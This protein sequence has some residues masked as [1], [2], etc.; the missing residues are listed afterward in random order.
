MPFAAP[1]PIDLSIQ[2]G[3]ACALRGIFAAQN[4]ELAMST[5]RMLELAVF[6][7]GLAVTTPVLA[8]TCT[9][10]GH[11]SCTITCPAGCGA[12]YN[13]PNGPCTTFCSSAATNQGGRSRQGSSG[14]IKGATAAEI[15]RALRKK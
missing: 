5:K 12:I 3:R 10:P 7:F 1:L 6:G 13:E 11:S 15:Q 4:G 14:E 2:L 9:A 8:S